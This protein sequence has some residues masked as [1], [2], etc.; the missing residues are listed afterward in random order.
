MIIV[1]KNKTKTKNKVYRNLKKLKF[2]V[3]ANFNFIILF[4][5]FLIYNPFNLFYG[6]SLSKKA[7]FAAGSSAVSDVM[8]VTNSES[9]KNDNFFLPILITSIVIL[10]ILFF[11]MWQTF[12][13]RRHY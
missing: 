4:L 10:S 6:K 2:Y 8:T 9:P 13:T 11:A 5:Y 3:I 1:L 7:L 12:K